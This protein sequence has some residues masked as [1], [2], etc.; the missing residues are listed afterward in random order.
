MLTLTWQSLAPKTA[1][2][3]TKP[4]GAGIAIHASR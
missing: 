2:Q 4:S 3:G 1:A